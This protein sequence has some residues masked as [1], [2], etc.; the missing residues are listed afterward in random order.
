MENHEQPHVHAAGEPIELGFGDLFVS[1][2]DHIGHYYQ[3]HTE[4]R[5]V[6]VGFLAAGLNGRDKC[7]YL[8]QDE[9]WRGVEEQLAERGIDIAAAMASGQLVV[10]EGRPSPDE[11]RSRLHA[12][13]AEIPDPFQM[14]R[15]VGDMTWSFGQMADTETLMEWETMC[16]VVESPPAVFLCQYDLRRFVGS[17]IIDAMKSHP[18]SIIGNTVHQ[19]PYYVDPEA[20]LAEIRSRPATQLA[21]V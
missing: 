3:N 16:N 4:S 7:V 8:C 20:F 18:L 11:L 14:V 17:V 21:V 5:D 10:D 15:W 12:A 2:G 19:N 13:L 6:V 1:V 9:T